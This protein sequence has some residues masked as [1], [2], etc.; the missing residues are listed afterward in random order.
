MDGEEA[1]VQPAPTTFQARNLELAARKLG[2]PIY[3]SAAD[4]MRSGFPGVNELSSKDLGSSL[5][6]PPQRAFPI[7][8]NYYGDFGDLHPIT[9]R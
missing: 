5:G 1:M 8:T 9:P 3:S 4:W 6:S 2:L 7:P